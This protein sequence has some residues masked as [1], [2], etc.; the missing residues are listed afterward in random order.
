MVN[1][2]APH[3]R[4]PYW[5]L[6]VVGIVVGI[7]TCL[8]VCS[9][10]A[11][12]FLSD[13]VAKATPIHV[14]GVLEAFVL[15]LGCAGFVG[16]LIA[17]RFLVIG[18]HL[19][20]QRSPQI[21]P[22]VLLLGF[23]SGIV[24]NLLWG[25]ALGIGLL[26]GGVEQ[27]TDLGIA[28][29]IGAQ[30]MAALISLAVA[31]WTLRFVTSYTREDPREIGFSQITFARAIKWGAAGYCA[32][33]PLVVLAFAITYFIGRITS[34]QIFVPEHPIV[35]DLLSGRFAFVAA[36]VLAVVVAPVVEEVLFRGMLYTALRGM[37]GFWSAAAVSAFAFAVVHPTMPA[38]FLPLAA[39]GIVLAVLRESTGSVAPA[40]VCHG[41]NNALAL[42]LVRL[43]YA[44]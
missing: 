3:F 15:L 19:L 28:A 1:S 43:I 42:I 2:P 36:T 31:L 35:Y 25:G 26:L 6:L 23:L 8:N 44:S 7:I 32:A 37:M 29:H 14:S 39:L 10:V 11:S 24:S 33:L 38:S 17:V 18:M 22:Q 40:I 41:I 20:V 16:L 13:G 30:S 34:R 9:G 21:Q 12:N 5:H 27:L 4:V